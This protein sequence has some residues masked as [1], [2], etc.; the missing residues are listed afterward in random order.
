[1]YS[2][3][4]GKREGVIFAFYDDKLKSILL[5]IRDKEKQDIFFTNGSVEEKDKNGVIN[6]YKKNALFREIAEEF[7][8]KIEVGKDDVHF[9][10]SLYVKEINV[11]F[12]IY[13][14][15]KWHGDFPK[16]T[17]EDKEEFAELIWTPFELAYEKIPY[18][19][20]KSILDLIKGSGLL[21]V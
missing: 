21:N 16:Y 18:D 15:S 12:Y 5:E 14:I 2:Y 17:I 10:N 11:I 9:I 20:G 3:I 1:M 7:S 8:E 13:L 6:D 4:D 19:S